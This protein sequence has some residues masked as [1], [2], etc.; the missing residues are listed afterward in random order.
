MNGQYQQPQQP[1]QPQYQQP[2]YQPPVYQAPKAP[3]AGLESVMDLIVKLASII[4]IVFL[5]LGAL[6]ILFNLING[7]VTMADY[8]NPMQLLYGLVDGLAGA[9][10]YI[11]YAVVT[12]IGTKLLKK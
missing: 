12:V 1:Q 3:G 7:V 2:Q 11:F 9:A 5:G 8:G 6:S 10:K 4:V